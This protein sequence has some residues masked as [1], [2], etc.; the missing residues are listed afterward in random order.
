MPLAYLFHFLEDPL[1]S[2]IIYSYSADLTRILTLKKEEDAS[3]YD[4]KDNAR[5]KTPLSEKS[6]SLNARW[7]RPEI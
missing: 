2:Q 3:D 6:S 7:K 4:S 1:N 5:I